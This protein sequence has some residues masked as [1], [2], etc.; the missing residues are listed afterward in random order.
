MSGTKDP[1]H[2]S[3]ADKLRRK[4]EEYN[5]RHDT[6]KVDALY[7]AA[8]AEADKAAKTG[9]FNIRYFNDLLEDEQTVRAFHK[10]MILDGFTVSKVQEDSAFSEHARKRM[11]FVEIK[12]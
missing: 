2:P 10:R 9:S 4:A 11:I 5:D 8:V 1:S 12:W 3:L 7:K 6:A